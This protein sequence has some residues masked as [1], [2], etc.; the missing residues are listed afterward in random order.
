MAVIALKDSVKSVRLTLA[1]FLGDNMELFLSFLFFIGEGET[2]RL[3]RFDLRRGGADAEGASPW[4][5]TG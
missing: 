5:S 1:F 3:L 4:L 2:T